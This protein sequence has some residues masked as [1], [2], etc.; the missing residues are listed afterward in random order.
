M[1]LALILWGFTV[2]PHCLANIYPRQ[3]PYYFSQACD[4][5]VTAV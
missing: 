4:H 5:S 1:Y 2:F 3:I